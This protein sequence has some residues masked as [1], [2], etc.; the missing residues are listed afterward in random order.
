MNKDNF[1]ACVDA[2]KKEIDEYYEKIVALRDKCLTDIRDYLKG[3]KGNSISFENEEDAISVSYNGGNH[4]EYA[5]NAYSLVKRVYFDENWD[6]P[7]TKGIF[8]DIEDTD[9]YSVMELRTAEIIELY[10]YIFSKERDNKIAYI[11]EKA[12]KHEPYALRF[13]GDVEITYEDV[14]GEVITNKINHI[15]IEG[16]DDV[17]A[18]VDFTHG[19]YVNDLSLAALTE[20]EIALAKGSYQ[21]G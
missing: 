10:E 11:T 1:F 9:W 2:T 12:K 20:I 18:Y 8:L 3:I 16:E 17:V 5:S 15:A 21:V 7:M 14:D 13:I 4:P 19:P 6:M